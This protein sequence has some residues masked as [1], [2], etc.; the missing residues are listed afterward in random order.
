MQKG[1]L[2]KIWDMLIS[3]WHFYLGVPVS[4]KLEDYNNLKSNFIEKK[5]YLKAM[6]Y[7]SYQ[8]VGERYEEMYDYAV[9]KNISLG[10]ESMEFYLNDPKE[11]EKEKLETMILISVIE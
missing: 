11:V 2:C 5:R 4:Q 3:K 10:S 6:H 1:M 7:G 8:K 9:E